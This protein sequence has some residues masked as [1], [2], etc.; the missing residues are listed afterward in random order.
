M[1]EI[2]EILVE[3]SIKLK[4]SISVIFSNEKVYKFVV[5]LCIK[6]FIV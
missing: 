6:D 3:E 4:N 2:V 5:C 1:F